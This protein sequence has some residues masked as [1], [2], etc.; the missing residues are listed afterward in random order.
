MALTNITFD[1]SQIT[2]GAAGGAINDNTL[3]A[4]GLLFTITAQGSWTAD[5]SNNR[6]NF[7]ED[8]AFGGLPP[9]KWPSL[10]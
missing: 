9:E 4:G 5:F 7:A 1:P 3:E 8:P 10:K 2:D 6:F